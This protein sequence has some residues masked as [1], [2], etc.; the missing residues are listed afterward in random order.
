MNSLERIR[1]SWSADR[2]NFP[3]LTSLH[4]ISRPR[5]QR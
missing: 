5:T 1:D 4:P 3:R 2:Q